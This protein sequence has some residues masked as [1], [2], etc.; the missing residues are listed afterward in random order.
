MDWPI[1]AVFLFA[2]TSASLANAAVYAWAWN[3]R[4][5]SPWQST[6]PG[7]APRTWS[8]RLPI[9]GWLRL[10]RDA[11]VLGAGFWVRPM[12]VEAAFGLTMAAL[13][14]W[15]V[16]QA[17]LIAPRPEALGAAGPFP[18]TAWCGFALHFVLAW[19]MLVAS[20]IDVDE[21]TIPDEVTVPGT[22]L[23]L[24]LATLLPWGLPPNVEERPAPPVIGVRV[25]DA[26]GNP[27]IGGFGGSVWLEPTHA[28][29]PDDWPTVLAGGQNRASLAIGL[30]CYLLW[31][32]ALTTRIW[33]T[34]RGVVHGLALLL[35][36]VGR[37]LRTRPLREIVIGGVLAITAVWFTD[38]EA[39]IGLLTSLIGLVG[40]GGIVWAVR[41]IGSAALKKEAMGFGDVT[42]MMMVGAFLGWQAGLMV[43]FLAPF[44]GLVIGVAQ[45]T[46]RRGDVLPYGPFLCL[47]ACFVVVRWGDLWPR[48]ESLFALGAVVPI[49]L[50]VCLTLLG[51]LLWLWRLVKERL[52]GVSDD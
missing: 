31:C 30:G 17:G 25:L 29:A 50:V 13:C 44:A 52:L 27:A 19:L 51:V 35:T 2:A 18:A 9:V 40:G 36:R 5:V 14:W 6:P 34:R 3:S 12:L 46:L 23:G 37:D 48:I 4:L 39:W 43:F 33:R 28:A 24:F 32:F 20:L 7:V 21:K 1:A 42:L 45:L 26:A 8:D 22:L 49:V 41:I 15:E 11:A 38:G 47:A 16:R 10:R